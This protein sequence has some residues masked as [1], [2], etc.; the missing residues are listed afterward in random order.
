MYTPGNQYGADV[1]AYGVTVSFARIL[2]RFI[3]KMAQLLIRFDNES[4]QSKHNFQKKPAETMEFIST[5]ASW[6]N[7]WHHFH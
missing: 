4:V 5:L 2:N 7:D 6:F 1:L 3:I